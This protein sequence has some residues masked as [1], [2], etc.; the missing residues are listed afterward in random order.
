M[1]P[2]LGIGTCFLGE[3]PEAAAI[4]KAAIL[5]GLSLGMN[6][7][8]TAE[9]YGG[10]GSESLIGDMLRN[11]T[12]SRAEVIIVTKVCPQNASPPTLFKS[13][14]ASL[15]RLGT[16]Y[17]DIY[18]LHW[19]DD[20]VSL[21]DTINGME[22]LV[23]RGDIRRWGV[24]NFDVRDMEDLF[25][26]PEGM[27][28]AVNQVLYHLGSRGIEYDLLPWLHSH[29]VTAMAYCPL[30]QGGKLRRTAADFHTNPA[31]G[32]LAA[33]YKASIFQI[34]LAFVL[35]NNDI[36]AIPKAANIAHIEENAA[37]PALAAAITA[38]EWAAIDVTYPPP[39]YKMHLDMD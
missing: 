4:E 30:A 10:G 2:L 35:R 1:I 29:G 39:A 3:S 11:R 15:K 31:L 25:L 13:C 38:D 12:I 6:L 19:R 9:M 21:P 5:R 26:A 23:R 36:C 7:L 34:M 20:C 32:A 8:D 18:L 17:I 14:E 24:S 28:C 33:K 22:E 27:R 37:A 16:D